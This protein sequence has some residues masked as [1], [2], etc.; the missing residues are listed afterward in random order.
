[1]SR[2]FSALS[3]ELSCVSCRKHPHGVCARCFYVDNLADPDEPS[4][5]A[6]V[7]GHGLSLGSGC[8]ECVRLGREVHR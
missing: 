7:C 1:M 8:S 5:W 6:M 4:V 2:T 3:V